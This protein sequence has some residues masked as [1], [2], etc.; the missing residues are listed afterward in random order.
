MTD[1]NPNQAFEGVLFP[2]HSIVVQFYVDKNFLDMYCYNRSQDLFLGTPFN[3]AYSALLLTL[4]AK[5]SDLTPRHLH[6]GLGDVH[7]YK[8]HYEA[9]AIQIS[10]IPYS[11]PKIEVKK[12]LRTLED[13]EKLQAEDI[14]LKNYSSHSAIKADMVA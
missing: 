11:F 13:L 12:S 3:I 7:I 2:C 8:E 10:R 1:Y 14:E 9:V 5:I 4:I 6:M